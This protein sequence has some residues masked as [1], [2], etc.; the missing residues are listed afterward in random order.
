MSAPGNLDLF[1][2]SPAPRSTDAKAEAGPPARDVADPE[3]GL[4]EA[5]LLASV[6]RG[7]SS[8]RRVVLTDNR[9]TMLSVAGRSREVLRVQRVFARAPMGVLEAIGRFFSRRAATERRAARDTIRAFLSDVAPAGRRP[10]RRSRRV[11]PEDAAHIERLRREFDR[12]NRE[13]F[14][15]SL[16]QAPI[17]LSGAMRRRNGHFCTD[18]VEIVISRRL[19]VLGAPGEA[20]HTLRHEM[21]HLWQHSSGG[22]LGHGGDFRRW[23]R[24]LDV[25]PRA[26][27]KVRWQED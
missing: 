22:T 10:R 14:G 9:R 20:E 8:F 19:C 15:G 2:E 23:A 26:T 18:P 13:H 4:I 11:W 7:G 1:D 5:D 21:I 24:A 12:V 27:R 16:P 17:H 3:S 6:N 25:H